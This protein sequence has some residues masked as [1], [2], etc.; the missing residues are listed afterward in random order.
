MTPIGLEEMKE[1]TD[2]YFLKTKLAC[3][4]HIQ[5]DDVLHK[6]NCKILE[7]TVMSRPIMPTTHYYFHIKS[8]D[9]SLKKYEKKR[10]CNCLTIC[11]SNL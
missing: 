10:T 11:R 9:E 1:K 5:K 6:F 7:D 2:G 3:P 4:D 8:D